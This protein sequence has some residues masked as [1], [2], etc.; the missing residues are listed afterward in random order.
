[1]VRI[2][3]YVFKRSKSTEATNAIL[4]A[5][6][7]A[8]EALAASPRMGTPRPGLRRGLRSHRLKSYM[9]FYRVRRQHIEISRVL[10]QRQDVAKAFPKRKRRRRP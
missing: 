7:A 1:V 2:A 4:E 3:A 9:I 8:F 10:S 5:L 6:Y